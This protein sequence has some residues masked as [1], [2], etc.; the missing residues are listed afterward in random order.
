MNPEQYNPQLIACELT[1]RC[2]CKCK[3]C[4]AGAVTEDDQELSTEQWQ[5][6]FSSI[7]DLN[8]T[9]LI[10]TGGEPME[11][12]DIYEL[13]SFGKKLGHKM[14]MATCGYHINEKSIRKLKKQGISILSFSIDGASADTHDKFRQT[15]GS[16]DTVIKAAQIAKKARV[17][18]QINTTISKMNI[19]E[20]VGIAELAYRLGADCFNPFI[21]VPTGHGKE[22]S[23]A[24]LDP[25]EYE[26]VLH[27]L[28]RLKLESKI[29]LRVTCSPQFNKLLMQ[30]K[31]EKIG[32]GKGCLGGQTFSFISYCGDVQTCGFLDISA[33]NL[34]KNNYNFAKVW[35]NSYLLNE[36]R[37]RDGYTGKCSTCAYLS[38]CGGCRA[39]AHEMSG[40]HLGPD[41]VCKNY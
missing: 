25:I 13:I 31:V 35:L 6:I 10:L 20:F 11:R 8:K 7:A 28:L 24:I 12:V 1:R 39:R 3:H 36:I 18:F 37:N 5:N 32:K 26:M 15:E 17:K 16:F 34:V 29:K 27:E 2:N 40:D 14:A 9:I 19:D 41:P 38:V 30:E 23:D 21:F 22:I 4:R 33:G